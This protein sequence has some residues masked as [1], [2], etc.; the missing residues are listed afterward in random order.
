MAALPDNPAIR[1]F[2][3]TGA[4]FAL[5]ATPTLALL[6]WSSPVTAALVS[7]AVVVAYLG[8]YLLAVGGGWT[9][10]RG[11]AARTGEADDV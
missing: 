8:G 7:A 11:D 4:L 3:V 1:W 6:P 5:L 10:L 9:L 2:L